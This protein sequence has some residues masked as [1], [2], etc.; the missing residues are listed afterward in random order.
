[1]TKQ[2][3]T[4]FY[5]Q[6]E[7]LLQKINTTLEKLYSLQKSD[8]VLWE[9]MKTDFETVNRFRDDLFACSNQ[10]LAVNLL[11]ALSSS[12]KQKL[13]LISR[14]SKKRNEYLA[15]HVTLLEIMNRLGCE[16]LGSDELVGEPFD[17]SWQ[18]MLK[19]VSADSKKAPGTI[20]NFVFYGIRINDRLIRPAGG[21]CRHRT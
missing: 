11:C 14:Q 4:Q 19:A 9:E 8:P 6:L 21:G 18:S 12:L 2:E 10:I 3:Q 1:M 15:I 5:Q 17:P 16:V 13:D 7:P 20:A